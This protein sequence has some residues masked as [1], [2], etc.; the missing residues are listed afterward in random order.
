M[1]EFVDAGKVKYL[2]VSDADADTIRRAHAVHPISALQDEYSIFAHDGEM[3]FPVLEEL[4]IGFVAYS[5]LA[6]GFLSGAVKSR[7]QTTPA[8][9]GSAS[10]GGS[11]R[12]TTPTSP[13]SIS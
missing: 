8:T 13:S 10:P 3:L 9:T 6:R 11:R 7:D 2:G 12:T 4:R 5:P 1:K